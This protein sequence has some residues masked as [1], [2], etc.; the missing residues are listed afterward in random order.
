MP[1]APGSRVDAYELIRPLGRGGMG[2]VW[3][4][5]EVHLRRK[6]ALKLLPLDL[7]R[8]TTRVTR[9]QQE[10]RAASALSHP[11]VCVIHALGMTADGQH[12]IAMEYVEG[13]TLRARLVGERLLLR[14]A[15]DIAIQIAS[16]LAAAHASGIVHRDIK[17]ENV[18]L[19]PDGVVKV[20]DFGLA[21]LTSAADSDAAQSTQTAFRTEAGSVVGTVAYMSPEQARGQPVDAR[22]DI[23]SL[24]VLLYEMVAGRSPFPGQSS[25]D[26]LAAILQNEPAPLARF[27][28]DLPTELQRIVGKTL[29]K[30]RSQR[31]QTVQDLLLDLQ[32]LREEIQSQA[33][34]GSAPGT[35]ITTE[36][37]ASGS[38]QTVPSVPSRRRR[39]ALI[40]A[41]TVLVL[42]AVLGVWAL[43]TARPEQT[44]A[45]PT[46]ALVQRNLT[47]LTFGPGLQTDVTW[48]PDGTRI[49]Y[50]SDLSGNFDIWSQAVSGGDPVQITKSPSADTQ[51][52]WS[53]D[54]QDIVFRS[55]RGG[56]GLYMVPAL[57]GPE[58][59]LSSFGVHPQ[60]SPDGT[61]I[62]FH[63]VAQPSLTG[64]YRVSPAGG[65]PPREEV[66]DFVRGGKW[67]WMAFHPDGRL[68]MI[69]L[70]R[71]GE[72]GFFTVSASDGRVTT[73]SVAPELPLRVAAQ[74]TRIERFQWNAT[75]DALFA[76]AI[77]NEVRNVW[78]IQVEPR[79]LA[80]RSAERLTTGMGADVAAALSADG[81]RLLFS[82]QRQSKRLWIFPFDAAA[83]RLLGDGRPVSPDEGEARDA[84]LAPD[85]RA[86]AY[87]LRRAGSDRA[88]LWLTDLDSGRSELFARHAVGPCWSPEGTMIAYSLFR[89]DR[90]PPGE[91][92]LAVREL[93]GAERVLGRWSS[94]EWFDP[95]DWTRDGGAIL[96]V[97]LS[98]LYTG[99]ARLELWPMDKTAATA[100]DRVLVTDAQARIWQGRYSPD[101]RWI[102]FVAE[103]IDEQARFGQLAVVPAAGGPR[104][105]WTR[106][107][108]EHEVAD[109][110]RW[111][112]D[113]RTLYFIS[114]HNSSNFD[115]WGSRFDTTRGEPVGEPFR[116][117]H[118]DAP[119]LVVSPDLIGSQIGISAHRVLLTMTS[120]TGN[121][122]MLDNVDK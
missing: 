103:S 107:A 119:G 83:G 89:P 108:L 91:W 90:P 44:P 27:D 96:G 22:T 62:I 32:A 101:G 112:P 54:G 85:G 95:Q 82:A 16:A 39:A 43:R 37:V 66:K 56:G 26:V 74:G 36:P 14:E 81:A 31:Y 72:L 53:P 2:E 122:W 47:R 13:Q 84:A 79:T 29:R 78:K 15:L 68:S 34:S 59:Q 65:E 8:D 71:R 35:S 51:P 28:P 116:V 24:G 106:I 121:I 102:S 93:A 75:G 10:A 57:G 5:T 76:E 111:S 100:P 109:K 110:P 6:V 38:S 80:W 63:P 88:D 64:V 87:T 7:T 70:H 40:A 42:C 3:L 60:W 17:P 30:E 97:Y 114:R 19:R 21:K 52:A 117:T 12:Y 77:V 25:S 115:L 20:L 118:F 1:P 86:V 18:M 48:S 104:A 9:F 92:A 58:R 98:P 113:G 49:A 120:I 46:G 67:N 4:A 50:A 55:E 61:A 11:N 41:A 99:M 69:G 94:Q 73:S 105:A 33:R 45:A 23:W